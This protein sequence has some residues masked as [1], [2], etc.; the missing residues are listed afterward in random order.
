MLDIQLEGGSDPL[1]VPTI[2]NPRSRVAVV[3][4][5]RLCPLGTREGLATWISCLGLFCPENKEVFHLIY[6]H[7]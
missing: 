1:G 4:T 6:L 5:G 2:H 7:C 3:L